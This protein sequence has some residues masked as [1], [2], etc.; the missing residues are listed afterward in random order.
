MTTTTNNNNSLRALSNDEGKCALQGSDTEVKGQYLCVVEADT[1]N[2]N[3]IKI[4]NDFRFDSENNVT[5]SGIISKANIY[6]VNIQDIGNKFGN[7]K[8]QPYMY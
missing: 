7:S 4:G 5:I 6:M 2:I 8:I 3:Q 1:N